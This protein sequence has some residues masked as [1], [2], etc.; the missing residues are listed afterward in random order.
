M[1]RIDSSEL[2]EAELL[3]LVHMD[4][5]LSRG[6]GKDWEDETVDFLLYRTHF[7]EYCLGAHMMNAKFYQSVQLSALQANSRGHLDGVLLNDPYWSMGVTPLSN[8]SCN[9][10]SVLGFGGGIG[11]QSAG[12]AV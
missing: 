4:F 8:D 2:F 3:F 11:L 10:A 12:N 7:L 1:T 6:R 9:D 5:R